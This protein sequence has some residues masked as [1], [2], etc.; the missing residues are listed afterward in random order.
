MIPF[1]F[2]DY[3]HCVKCDR[4]EVEMIDKFNRPTTN[5]FYPITKMRCNA[6]GAVY[7]IRWTEDHNGNKIPICADSSDVKEFEQNITQFSESTRRK[8]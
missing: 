8:L 2:T 5:I 6:C 3:R 4:R 1:A 7:Y